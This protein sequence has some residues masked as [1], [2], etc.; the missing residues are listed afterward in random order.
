MS[1]A[2]IEKIW[3]S[4]DFHIFQ[5]GTAMLFCVQEEDMAREGA[6]CSESQSF[7]S[8]SRLSAVRLHLIDRKER[9]ICRRMKRM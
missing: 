1:G 3:K 2:H 8:A 7:C 9:A 6:A 5:A 4:Y